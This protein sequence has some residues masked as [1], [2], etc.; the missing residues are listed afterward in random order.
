MSSIIPIRPSFVLVTLAL[1]GCGSV[2]PYQ[3]MTDEELYDVAV[4]KYEEQDWQDVIRALDRLLLS[5]GSS[6]LAPEARL[7]LA[8]ANFGKEDYLTARSEYMR[9][10][11]R[12]SG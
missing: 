8:H 12:H 5:F 9:Y 2:D 3:G 11:D 6:D 7:L 1:L 10:L 4:Q